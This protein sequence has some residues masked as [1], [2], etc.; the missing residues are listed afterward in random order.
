MFAW[1]ASWMLKQKRFPRCTILVVYYGLLADLQQPAR[2]VLA[3]VRR[4]T[5]SLHSAVKPT[6]TSE[7][8]IT[9]IYW[10][11][12][13]YSASDRSWPVLLYC[14]FCVWGNRILCDTSERILKCLMCVCCLFRNM[15]VFNAHE[16]NLHDT[17][18]TSVTLGHIIINILSVVK[19]CYLLLGLNRQNKTQYYHL[20]STIQSQ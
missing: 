6:A 16:S 14:R 7:A 15:S 13:S 20:S 2:M 19:C 18:S 11:H 10:K 1:L 12:W 9:A 3:R 17:R 5:H 8:I 4:R